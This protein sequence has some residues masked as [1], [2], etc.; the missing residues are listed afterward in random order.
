V[1][2]E[3]LKVI[4][5]TINGN[6]FCISNDFNCR[7]RPERRLRD[8]DRDLLATAKFLVSHCTTIA[9]DIQ[10]YVI[11]LYHLLVLYRSIAY[12]A[13]HSEI[14]AGGAPRWYQCGV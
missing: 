6:V 9:V 4:S 7:I 5:G 10:L 1:N 14:A 3:K 13:Q 2:F 12:A 11:N 8:A